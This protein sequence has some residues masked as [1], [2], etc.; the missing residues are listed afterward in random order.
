[1]HD[2][3]R[4]SVATKAMVSAGW[5]SSKSK[6]W[7]TLQQERNQD[8]APPPI[9]GAKTGKMSNDYRVKLTLTRAVTTEHAG[10][11]QAT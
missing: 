3:T 5:V 9:K 11:F 10:N 4:D 1:M 8:T 7:K 6:A 2:I